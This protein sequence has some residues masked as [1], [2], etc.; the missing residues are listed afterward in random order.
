MSVRNSVSPRVM[1]VR[2][3]GFVCVGALAA[4]S[5][6]SEGS[7]I[8]TT[9]S[10]NVEVPTTGVTT[11]PTTDAPS[12]TDAEPAT[13]AAATSSTVDPVVE[14]D[15]AV[16][17]A[18]DL[19]Q[20]TFSDCL[21]ALPRCDPASLAVARAGDV[22][23]ANTAL[24]TE[25]N[26]LGYTVRDR[27][28]FRFVVED[29]TVDPSLTSAVATVCVADGSRLVLPNAAPDG[30]DVVID[31]EYTSGRTEWDVRLDADGVWRVYGSTSIGASAT[32]DVCG[33]G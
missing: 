22:L 31:D 3:A 21:V 17:A 4:C 23:A 29:V 8:A 10:V 19:A 24:I 12:T 25:W 15:V 18:I 9:V 11:S 5:S 2:A 6:S 32:E 13:T 30:G 20:A 14:A 27:D 28:A 26:S 33:A 16:R 1:L 7:P